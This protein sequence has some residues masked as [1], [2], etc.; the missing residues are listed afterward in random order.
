M[1][2]VSSA[3]Y[4]DSLCK[5][6]VGVLLIGWVPLLP[7]IQCPCLEMIWKLATHVYKDNVALFFVLCFALGCLWHHGVTERIS[8]FSKK[9][10]NNEANI[11]QAYREVYGENYNCSLSTKVNPNP[12]FEAY[13]ALEERHLLGTV[14]VL[15]AIEAFMRNTILIFIGYA[16]AFPF[17][18]L[19]NSQFEGCYCVIVI[20]IEIAFIAFVWYWIK[21]HRFVM[22]AVHKSVVEADL[23][24]T[25]KMRNNHAEN[26]L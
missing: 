3:T 14:H 23:Y 21:I 19:C 1:N 11:N 13:Y 16:I 18:M 2:P 10:I 20:L 25:K 7:P 26:I 8:Y 12:Y 6:C 22:V 15:E 24:I 9:W 5:L 4:Y 17:V